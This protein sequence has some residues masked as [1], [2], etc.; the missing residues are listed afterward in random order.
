MVM[1]LLTKSKKRKNKPTTTIALKAR[2]PLFARIEIPLC[3][4][5][6]L[7]TVSYE[8]NLQV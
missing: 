5:H 1:G 7:K 4:P 8:V 2:R 6:F 3:G